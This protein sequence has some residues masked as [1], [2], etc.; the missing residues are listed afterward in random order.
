MKLE[1]INNKLAVVTGGSRGV[2]MEIAYALHGEGCAVAITGRDQRTVVQAARQIGP[3]CHPFVCD[4]RNPEA[5]AQLAHDVSSKLGSPEILINNAAVMIGGEVT[6]LPLER[7]NEVIETNLTGVFLTTQAFLKGMISQNQGDI[8]IIDSMSGL[9]GDPG[10]AAYAASK[11]GLRGFAQSLMHEMRQYNIRVMTLCPSS[12]NTGS[13][14]GAR[15]GKGVKLHSS[16]IAATILHML[17]LPGR[18]L[19]REM[20]LWGTNP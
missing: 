18:C 12:I 6:T 15:Y 11:F 13:A 16:D 7:W 5:I 20:E 10:S 3:R 9:R 2:G 8:F 14:G 4:Q 1:S 17:K 19:I